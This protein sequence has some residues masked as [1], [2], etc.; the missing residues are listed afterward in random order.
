MPRERLEPL[1][2]DADPETRIPVNREAFLPS[3]QLRTEVNIV[4]YPS[5]KKSHFRKLAHDPNLL[6]DLLRAFSLANVRRELQELERANHMPNA[7]VREDLIAFYEDLRLRMSA[8]EVFFRV[9]GGKTYYDN[10]L[11]LTIPA[12]VIPDNL[13]S[14]V[15]KKVLA[16][17]GN[18]FT[19]AFT[20]S[21]GTERFW[22]VTRTVAFDRQKYQPPG[23]VK[24]EIDLRK[25]ATSS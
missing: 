23:W 13:P 11:A 4:P 20:N 1:P 25:A 8:G 15:R 3:V 24:L 7:Q 10:S 6:G 16:Q 12:P 22:P 9:G 19:T 21:D 5:L 17:S 18:S 14:K 2:A